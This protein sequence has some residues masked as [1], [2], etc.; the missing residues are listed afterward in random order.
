[1]QT[2]TYNDNDYTAAKIYLFLPNIHKTEFARQCKCVS[3]FKQNSHY[4]TLLVM[5]RGKLTVIA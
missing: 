2:I 4:I 3:S 5:L 1:M